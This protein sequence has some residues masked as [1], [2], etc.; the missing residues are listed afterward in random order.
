MPVLTCR[1]F[2]LAPALV[3][4]ASACGDGGGGRGSGIVQP[5]PGSIQ[6]SLTTTGRVLDRTGYVVHLNGRNVGTVP[7]NGSLDVASIESGTYTV[8]L[9]DVADN[10]EVTGG[11]SRTVAVVGEAPQNV[12]FSVVCTANRISFSGAVNGRWMLIVSTLD[13]ADT[14]HVAPD[15]SARADWSPDGHNLAYGT[16]GARRVWIFDVDAG[17]SRMLLPDA[18]RMFSQHPSWSPDGSRIAFS[19]GGEDGGISIYTV[20]TD[21]SDLR[22]ITPDVDAVEYFPVWSPD[23]TRIAYRRDVR[24]EAPQIWI[25]NADGTDPHQVVSLGNSFDLPFDWSPDGSR[26]VFSAFEDNDWDLYTIRPDGT[27]RV[28]LTNTSDVLEWFPSFL[29]DGRIGYN[30]YRM[31]QDVDAWVMNPDGSGA[32]NTTNSPLVYESAPAWQ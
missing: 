23:G 14:I 30:R 6:V 29:P 11:A 22:A 10:C 1:P 31:G 7:G 21:G 19:G 28:R 20:N 18:L 3:I 27:S 8:V 4:A 5:S 32:E 17:V 12:E 9:G 2:V 24:F 26:I 25:V 15:V 13:G 16:L